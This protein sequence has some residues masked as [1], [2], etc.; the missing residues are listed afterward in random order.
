[1]VRVQ[2]GVGPAGGGCG[3]GETFEYYAAAH[4]GDGAGAPGAFGRNVGGGEGVGRQ[5]VQ[6]GEEGDDVAIVYA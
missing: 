5:E 2:R 3:T 1:M 6:G 4:G